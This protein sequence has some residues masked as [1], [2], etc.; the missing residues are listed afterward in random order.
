MVTV[1]NICYL[2]ANDKAGDIHDLCVSTT[3]STIHFTLFFYHCLYPD[4]FSPVQKCTSSLCVNYLSL[5]FFLSLFL[6]LSLSFSLLV[7]DVWTGRCGGLEAVFNIC[8]W[9]YS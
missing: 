4:H 5:S 1:V 6:S 8:Q 9:L 2:P 7:L 3:R